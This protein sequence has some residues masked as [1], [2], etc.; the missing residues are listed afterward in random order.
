MG[1]EGSIIDIY[2][3]STVVSHPNPISFSNPI[4]CNDERVCVSVPGESG[5]RLDLTSLQSQ[6]PVLP[7]D[8]ALKKVGSGWERVG[9][10]GKVENKVETEGL[11]KEI[12]E[13][14]LKE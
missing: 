6:I 5:K 13:W 10:G 7:S 2:T 4:S 9:T 14:L 3:Y 11:K 1:K 8:I 12:F